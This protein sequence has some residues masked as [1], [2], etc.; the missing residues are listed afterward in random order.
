MKKAFLLTFFFLFAL[1][2]SC[3]ESSSKKN[4]PTTDRCGSLKP[5]VFPIINGQRTFDPNVVNLTDSQVKAIGALLINNGQALCSATLIAPNVILTAAHCVS[6]GISSIAFVGGE[7][8]MRPE[9]IFYASEWH[10]HPNFAWNPPEFDLGIVII[11]GDTSSKGITPIPPN[12]QQKGL[13]NEVIQ[14]VGYGSTSS[15]GGMNTRRWWTTLTVTRQTP[16]YYSAYGYELTGICQGDSGGPML[17]T[18]PDGLPYVMGVVSAGDSESCLGNAF[19]PRT[20]FYCDDFIKQYLPPP[21]PCNGETL[22]GRCDGQTAIWCES[23]TVNQVDCS[24]SGNLCA[25]NE[26]GNF[27][28]VPPPDP[29]EGETFEGRC[30]GNVAIWCEGGVIQRIECGGT[31]ICG[32][33][34]DGLNRC[35][36]ECTLIGRKGRCDENGNARWCDSGVIKTRD[37]VLCG[38]SCGWVDENMGY[39]C[40]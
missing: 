31:T 17:Y 23:E 33:L 10:A 11:N 24:I 39:Y 3:S 25:Q 2:N 30:D 26:D 34:E 4:E 37:C 28:C 22:Q 32:A 16:T 38:Q 27:R 5:S 7:D 40:Y 1:F 29:C 15:S 18:M 21:D 6:G 35:V 13:L 9:F 36:D 14:A 8:L 12:C 19:Y 20:D